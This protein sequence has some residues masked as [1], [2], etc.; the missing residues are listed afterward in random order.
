MQ[1]RHSKGFL[2][3]ARTEVMTHVNDNLLRHNFDVSG[4]NQKRVS[5]ITYI[6]VA[7]IWFYLV[8]EL[9]LLPRKFLAGHWTV[10]FLCR[11]SR[12]LSRRE[13]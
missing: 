3:R 5:N 12:L 6:K 4:S 9:D 10:T 7:R 1:A 11:P 8:A 2:Y 13:K